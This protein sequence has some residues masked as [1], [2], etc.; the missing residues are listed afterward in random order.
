MKGQILFITDGSPSA[1][2]AGKIAIE[3]ALS[4]NIPLKAVFI[5]DEGWK[6]LLGD[7]WINTSSTRMT[8]FQW[9]EDG[10]MK[11]SDDILGGFHQKALDRGVNIEVEVKIGKTEKVMAD[12]TNADNTILLFLPNPHSTAPAAAAGLRYSLNSLSKKIKCPIYVG[13]R[14]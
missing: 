14:L 13:P 10:L 1:E 7:E 11:H 8:F 6:H 4:A 12:L 3:M 9:Y 5:F 2:E